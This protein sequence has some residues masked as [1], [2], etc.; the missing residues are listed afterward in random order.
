VVEDLNKRTKLV[1][2]S[3]IGAHASLIVYRTQDEDNEGE[4]QY[5]CKIKPLPGCSKVDLV[6]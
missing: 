6:G 4:F 2:R 3:V 1:E 5:H